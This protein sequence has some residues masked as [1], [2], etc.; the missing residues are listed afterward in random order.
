[1]RNSAAGI[2]NSTYHIYAVAKADGTQDI[3]AHTSTT[4]ATVLTAL[5]AETGGGS[6][7]YARIIGSIVR[8]SATIIGFTQVGNEFILNAQIQDAAGVSAATTSSFVSLTVPTGLNL[9]ANFI[10]VTGATGITYYVQSPLVT[11]A[12]VS[13]TNDTFNPATS[14]VIGGQLVVVTDT[15]GRVRV[16]S[17]SAGGTLTINTIGWFHPRGQNA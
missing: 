13:G 6:Y 3:Y 1:M 15:S 2:A 17:S 7:I 12:A 8:V 10:V 4:V 16:R 5:Q 14:T 9:R 11:D